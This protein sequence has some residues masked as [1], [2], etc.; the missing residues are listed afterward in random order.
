MGKLDPNWPVFVIVGVLVGEKYYQRTLVPRIKDFKKR[1]DIP[2]KA[3]L[4]SKDIRRC[5]N[6]FQ[7]LMDPAKKSRFYA[8]WNELF[9][10]LRIRIYA[11]VVDKRR[12]RERFLVP[13]NPYDVSLS[14]LLSI[15]CGAGGPM[16]K[17]EITQIIAESRGRVEDKELQA[18]YQSYRRYGL[19]NYGSEGVSNR[20]ASTVN[21]VFPGRVDFLRKAAVVAGLEL[22]DLAAYPIGRAVVNNDSSNP[23]LAVVKSK[24]RGLVLSP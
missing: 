19:F 23:A 10:S 7:F 1:H 9:L 24:L 4:H 14:Q 15:I 6:D 16:R 20:E 11:V 8:E 17:P 18:E 5:E 12:L 21:R 13:L 3:S 2:L 22:A